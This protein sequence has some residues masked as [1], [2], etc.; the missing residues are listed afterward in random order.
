M[1]LP[2]GLLVALSARRYVRQISFLYLLFLY[3][4]SLFLS[5]SSLFLYFSFPFLILFFSLKAEEKEKKRRRK[6]KEKEKKRKRKGKGKGKGK[7]TKRQEKPEK[8]P[9]KEKRRPSEI[10]NIFIWINLPIESQS[11]RRESPELGSTR[12]LQIRFL[13][14]AKLASCFG[15]DIATATAPAGLF[16]CL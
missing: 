10:I 6:E 12:K 7:E 11:E 2:L 1:L 14:V 4:S 15:Q 5:F 8:R 13:L 16:V 3:F 9:R